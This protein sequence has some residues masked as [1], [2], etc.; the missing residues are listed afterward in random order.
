MRDGG[1]FMLQKLQNNGDNG[2][3]EAI[4]NS[5][6]STAEEFLR[7]G[8]SVQDGV[9]IAVKLHDYINVQFYGVPGISLPINV[10][11]FDEAIEQLTQFRLIKETAKNSFSITALGYKVAKLL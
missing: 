8:T 4:K 2:Q 9:I 3:I 10:T 11:D 1:D 7:K 5:L 6:H